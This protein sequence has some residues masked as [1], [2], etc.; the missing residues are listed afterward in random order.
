MRGVVVALVSLWWITDDLLDPVRYDL[1]I[2]RKSTC[3]DIATI[4]DAGNGE[5]ARGLLR[6]LLQ[7][8][9]EMGD[10]EFLRA[11]ANSDPWQVE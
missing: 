1:K 11:F 7:R 6:L 5:V 10:E 4:E 2:T 3:A 9:D 8:I